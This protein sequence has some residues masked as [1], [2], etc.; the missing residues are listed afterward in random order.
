MFG[1]A[2]LKEV[3][4]KYCIVEINA[5]LQHFV[6]AALMLN[7]PIPFLAAPDIVLKTE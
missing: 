1:N 3:N 7:T 4:E 5:S 6:P 2:W